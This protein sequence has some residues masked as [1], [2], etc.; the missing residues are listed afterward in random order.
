MSDAR[1]V[2]EK[3]D[4]DWR[5]PSDKCDRSDFPDA[6]LAALAEAGLVIVPRVPTEKMT[7]HVLTALDS[8][9]LEDVERIY[10]LFVEAANEP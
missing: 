8:C 1:T 9:A 2:I 3:V 4:D 6:I 7:Q 10:R 5:H